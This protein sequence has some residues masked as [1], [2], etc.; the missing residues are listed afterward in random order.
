MAQLP[1]EPPYQPARESVLPAPGSEIDLQLDRELRHLVRSAEPA[2][3]FSSLAHLCVPT[4]SD[5][6][7]IDIVEHGE[8]AYRIDYVRPDA[9]GA[10]VLRADDFDRTLCTP[11][12]WA[13]TGPDDTGYAGLMTHRWHERQPDATDVARAAVLA[14]HG[15]DTVTEERRFADAQRGEI[16]PQRRRAGTLVS[17]ERRGTYQPWQCRTVT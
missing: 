8:I 7:T 6:C 10:E 13:G 1:E 14:R 17:R 2:V 4:F 5:A 15:V 11:F 12:A 3:V 9:A 16:A